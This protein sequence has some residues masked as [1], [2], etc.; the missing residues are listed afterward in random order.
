M[1]RSFISADTVFVYNS[2]TRSKPLDSC[3]T[4]ELPQRTRRRTQKQHRGRPLKQSFSISAADFECFLPK[5]ISMS[6]C[7]TALTEAWT[8]CILWIIKSETAILEGDICDR[9][10]QRKFKELQSIVNAKQM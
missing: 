9:V 6:S 10:Q 3:C 2:V 4:L 8:K 7:C 5:L 1:E